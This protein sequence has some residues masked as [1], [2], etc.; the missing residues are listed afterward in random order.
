MAEERT[1]DQLPDAVAHAGEVRARLA[2]RDAAVFLDYDGTLTPIVEDPAQ[3]TLPTATRRAIEELAGRTTVAIVSG[4][5][6]QDVRAMVD[7][8]GIHYAGSHGF[9]ILTAE[10]ESIQKGREFLP[11]LDVAERELE[12]EL[13][14]IAGARVERKRF[15]IAVHTRQVDD[16]AVP[17]VTA[18]VDAVHAAHPDLRTTG[19]KRIVELRP[20]LAWHK[21]EALRFLLET[22]GLDRDDVVPIYVG[23]D[24]TD[25]DAF[26]A[27]GDRGIG[28]VVRG[29]DDTR[30]TAADYAFADTDQ[31]RVFLEELAEEPA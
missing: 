6:L 11:S 12:A 25:E 29:E 9:D 22:L 30:P 21:G 13:V 18:V 7:L 19:G 17:Q 3:A 31:V 28:L 14:G 16:A 10:G 27:L 1:I 23:D 24:V 5:D 15:A 4:R 2:G 26:T 8:P 20:D